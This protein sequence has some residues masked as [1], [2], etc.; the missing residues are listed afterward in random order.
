MMV[1]VSVGFEILLGMVRG[2]VKLACGFVIIRS[3]NK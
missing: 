3:L 2:M 1:V